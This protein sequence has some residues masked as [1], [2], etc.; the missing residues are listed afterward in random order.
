VAANSATRRG[1]T[2]KPF[3]DALAFER[4]LITPVSLLDAAR[5]QGKW[6]SPFS[7]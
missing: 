7:L 4:Q 2:P 6:Q 3:I 1:S 5:I